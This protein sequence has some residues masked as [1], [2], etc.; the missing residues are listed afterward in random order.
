MTPLTPRPAARRT[1]LAFTIL[2]ALFLVMDGTMKV[3]AV[4]PVAASFV[5][6]GYSPALAPAIGAL[7]L[8]CVLLYLLPATSVLGAVLLTG[9]LGGAVATHVRVG[10]PLLTHALFPVYLGAMAWAGLM[11]RDPQARAFL[12]PRLSRRGTPAGAPASASLTAA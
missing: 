2:A 10:N 3:L 8:V 5:E 6:L 1:G 11:L 4:A 12:L 7:L 9:Y